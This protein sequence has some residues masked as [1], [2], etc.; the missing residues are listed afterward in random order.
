MSSYEISARRLWPLLAGLVAA[1]SVIG[2]L[3]YALVSA[4]EKAPGL[5][6]PAAVTSPAQPEGEQTAPIPSSDAN[7]RPKNIEVNTEKPPV[8]FH[9]GPQGQTI[10]KVFGLLAQGKSTAQDHEPVPDLWTVVERNLPN[11]V[12]PSGMK[13]FYDGVMVRGPWWVMGRPISSVPLA[14]PTSERGRIVEARYVYLLIQQGDQWMQ[15][16]VLAEF[17]SYPDGRTPIAQGTLAVSE[18]RVLDAALVPKY[19]AAHGL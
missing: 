5:E 8:P 17:L 1:G 14:Q 15:V 6:P 19:K 2:G 3:V 10:I 11:R 9:E 13:D 12:I 18:L 4:S 16:K 7:L